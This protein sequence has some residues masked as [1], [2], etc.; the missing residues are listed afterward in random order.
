MHIVAVTAYLDPS[1]DLPV[2]AKCARSAGG[3][4]AVMP[5]LVWAWPSMLRRSPSFL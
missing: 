5:A 1:I 3:A 4:R 2:N